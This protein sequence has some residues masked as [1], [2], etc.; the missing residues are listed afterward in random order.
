MLILL[1]QFPRVSGWVDAEVLSQQFNLL[2]DLVERVR[3]Y[4]AVVP[5]GPPFVTET[6]R[7]LL[8]ALG[9]ADEEA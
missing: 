9:W 4:L 2:A 8:D 1:G 3:A 7:Q 5:W 6:G